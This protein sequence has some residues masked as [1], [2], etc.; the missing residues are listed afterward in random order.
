MRDLKM[1]YSIAVVTESQ[2]RPGGAPWRRA[3]VR[4]SR[5]LQGKLYELVGPV[6]AVEVAA[7]RDDGFELRRRDRYAGDDVAN[8]V[9]LLV[10]VPHELAP[11][12]LL[13]VA[14]A[15]LRVD[16]DTR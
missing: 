1:R 14:F 8:T 16:R 12:G 9:R 11:G 7:G 3:G 6:L 5:L 2:V 15:V 13:R 4:L 10:K